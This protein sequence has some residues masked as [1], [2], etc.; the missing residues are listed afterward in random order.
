MSKKTDRLRKNNS[1][2]GMPRALKVLGDIKYRI[3]VE[4][5]GVGLLTGV[6]VSA[7]RL[8]LVKIDE[9]RGILLEAAQTKLSIVI[10]CLLLL[11]FFTV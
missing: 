11:F 3:I 8:S 2:E 4:G 10:W 1:A 6:L 7:F 5:I 9:I